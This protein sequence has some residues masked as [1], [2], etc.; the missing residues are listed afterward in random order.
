[1]RR[2]CGAAVCCRNSRPAGPQ[3]DARTEANLL[4]SLT[5]PRKDAILGLSLCTRWGPW[6][7]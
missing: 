6:Q 2:L 4:K 7:M 1:M 5:E 3:I